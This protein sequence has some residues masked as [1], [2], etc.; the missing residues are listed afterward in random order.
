MKTLRY[1]FAIA[2]AMVVGAVA[3]AQTN[4]QRNNSTNEINVEFSVGGTSGRNTITWK[5]GS[6]GVFS[7]GSNLTVNGAFNGTPTGG[8]LD[9]SAVTVIGVSGGLSDGDKGDITVGGSGTTL[10]V[11]DGAI[12]LAK[13][14]SMA[15]ASLLGRNTGGTGA[16]EVLSAATARSL[17]GL[18]GAAL[19][20]IGTG[21]GTAAAG[22]DARITGAVQSTRT[23]STTSPLSGG[24]DMSANRTFSIADAAADGATKGAAA[25]TSGHFSA[26]SGVISLANSGVTAG[27]HGNS[28]HTPVI[29][30]DAQGRVVVIS[31]TATAGGGGMGGSYTV[32]GNNVTSSGNI[33]LA[34]ATNENIVLAP[35]GT[36]EVRVTGSANVTGNFT[37]GGNST[38]GTVNATS[39]NPGIITLTSTAMGALA[40]D[41]TKINN[42]KSISANSTLTFSATPAT[43]GIFGLTLTNSDAGNNYTITIPS[44]YSTKYNALITS[45]IIEASQILKL[46]WFYD[47]STYYFLGGEPFRIFDL[48]TATPIASDRVPFHDVSTGLDGKVTISN[49]GVAGDFATSNSTATFTNKTFDVGATGNVF[50][51]KGYIHRQHPDLVDGTN[52]TI[53]TTSTSIAYGHATFSHSAD[54]ASNYVEYYMAVPEDIDTSVA[55][56]ARLKV[57][58]GNTDTAT[59]RYVLSSVSVADSAVPTAA[60]LANP[61]NIDFASD[62]SGANGDVETSAW[63]TL[64]SWAGA[65]T[66]GQT[67]RIRLARDGNATE[68][69]STENSTEL[70]LV[71]EYGVTQ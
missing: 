26:S 33:T 52:A 8:T 3:S 4:L 50:K 23:I 58:L 17:L 60:T 49:L 10:T 57:L 47:G 51:A 5:T 29:Q 42:T 16:P 55:L 65:L 13:M 46:F 20:N 67:W 45:F 48:P 31:N 6:T 62:G 69:A 70:G 28:T 41:V 53:G 14:A 38:L 40:V 35:A 7:A 30:V 32:T 15:T 18:G 34:S 59:H 36:G 66:A 19:L 24:G 63:T 64:T 71:I 54:E 2:A 43:G 44:T 27:T 39:T 1:L 22:D 21:S 9:L 12:T 37:V 25:F 61:I 68:D 56:R 11:D